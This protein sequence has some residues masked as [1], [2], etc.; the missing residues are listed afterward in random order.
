MEFPV[1]GD[2]ARE[3]TELG[4]R[5]CVFAENIEGTGEAGVDEES[6]C[7]DCGDIDMLFKEPGS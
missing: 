1:T 4:N 6:D 5:V 2:E 7:G 3:E